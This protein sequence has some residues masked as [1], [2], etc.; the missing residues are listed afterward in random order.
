MLILQRIQLIFLKKCT[1]ANPA[2][3]GTAFFEENWLSSLVSFAYVRL[4]YSDI[5]R[6]IGDTIFKRIL[7]CYS[8]GTE[9]DTDE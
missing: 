6:M 9:R 5:D 7:G 2:M 3:D 1:V 4:D 8:G